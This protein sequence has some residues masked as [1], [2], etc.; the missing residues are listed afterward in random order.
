MYLT[1]LPLSYPDPTRGTD[2]FEEFSSLTKQITCNGIEHTHNKGSIP[3]TAT[4]FHLSYK[5]Q[6]KLRFLGNLKYTGVRGRT[7]HTA[8][9]SVHNI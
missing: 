3:D 9:D 2:M 4:Y 7:P 5:S 8:D 6:I 1:A